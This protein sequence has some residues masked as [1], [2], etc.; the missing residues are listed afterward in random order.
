MMGAQEK[1]TEVF[2]GNPRGLDR[3]GDVKNSFET[4]RGV[5]QMRGERYILSLNPSIYQW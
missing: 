1:D 5:F 4:Y 3:E 2:L